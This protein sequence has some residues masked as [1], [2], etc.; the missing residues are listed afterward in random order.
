MTSPTWNCDAGSSREYVHVPSALTTPLAARVPEGLWTRLRR[1]N[2]STYASFLL[3][4]IEILMFPL[5]ICTGELGETRYEYS[6]PSPRLVWV[7][8]KESL[9][10]AKF[11]FTVALS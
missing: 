3:N 10:T 6:R 2:A 8:P 4:G 5:M 1:T 9:A 11:G 7:Q